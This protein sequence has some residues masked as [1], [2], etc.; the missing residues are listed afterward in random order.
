MSAENLLLALNDEY[1]AYSFYTSVSSYGQVFVHLQSA[2]Q[3]HINALSWH[4]QNLGVSIPQN[5]Y[6]AESFANFSSIEEILQ[7]ALVNEN[8]NVELYNTLIANEKD[9]EVIDTFY[10]LQA[11]SFNNHIPSLSY[12][13]EQIQGATRDSAQNLQSTFQALS[14]GKVLLNEAGEMLNKMQ[15]GT[16]SQMELESFL[17]KLN[18]SLIGGVIVGALGASLLNEFLNQNKE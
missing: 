15:N 8:K 4:L 16:L 2:E 1:K 13:L 14:E 11:A 18:Y 3:T 12:T 6:N 10:R 17:H 9:L 7:T 5:P